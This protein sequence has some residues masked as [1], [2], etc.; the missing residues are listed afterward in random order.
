MRSEYVKEKLF[1]FKVG[2]CASFIIDDQIGF[3]LYFPSELVNF[4]AE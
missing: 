3:E 2:S 1:P 4:L